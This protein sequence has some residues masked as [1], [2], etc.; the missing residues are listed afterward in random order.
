MEAARK[1][2]KEN[3]TKPQVVQRKEFKG[4]AFI[5][6][7]E[8]IFFKDF[9]VGKTHVQT[10][11]LTNVS[12]S[13]N[14][15]KVLPLD[16]A[17]TDFFEIKYT[18]SGRMS[19]G[20]STTIQITFIP[21]LNQ[22]INSVLPLLAETGPINIP[23]ICTCK[24]AL[25]EVEQP[26]IDFGHVIFGEQATRNLHV[27]NN[28]ALPA[29]IFIKTSRGDL[30]P[31]L[32]ED[33]LNEKRAQ[34]KQKM[35]EHEVYKQRH[36]REQ[37]EKAARDSQAAEGQ[38]P[39]PPEVE[40][41]DDKE[42]KPITQDEIDRAL[43][44]LVFKED[45]FDEFCVQAIFKR[46]NNI[47]S[48]TSKNL[49]FTFKPIKLGR[50]FQECT[51]YLDNQDYTEPIPIII[52]GECVDVPIHV[53]R[54]TYNLNILVYEKTYREK[55]VLYNRSSNTMKLQLY[56]PKEL[57]NY[58]EFNPTLGYIQ[59]NDKFEIWMKF[60]PD[61]TIL[62]V[63]KKYISE[64]NHIDIPIKVVG[65][66]QVIPVRFNIIGRFTVNAVTFNPPSIDFGNVYHTSA[67]RVNMTMENHSLLPQQFYFANLPREIKVETDNGCGIILPGESYKFTI[68]YRPSQTTTYEESEVFC[69]II[70]GNI[71]SREVKISYK[72][73]VMRL[74]LKLTHSLIEFPGLPEKETVEIVTQIENPTQKTYMVELLPP[75]PKLS[76]IMLTPVVMQIPPQKSSLVSIKYKAAFRDFN[77]QTLEKLRKEEE[78]GRRAKEVQGLIQDDEAA[79]KDLVEDDEKNKKRKKRRN[80]KLGKYLFQ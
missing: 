51:L 1:R 79:D 26:I 74:P 43:E 38:Q 52:K 9:D 71:C 44:K 14:S 23:L 64:G 80:K 19:A 24:K 7:P 47:G 70:T 75:N 10:I 42:P 62:S 53:E 29:K 78:A 66:N 28:G 11:L 61:R 8:T 17:I 4:T 72:V 37:Q 58:L 50:I 13:F 73:N 2:H 46:E 33:E 18:P 63:G 12:F 67:S 3:L 49:S 22:D 55:I 59:G 32:T 30:I 27:V 15:F 54:L 31:D 20:L 5:S 35:I 39:P 21:Q 57:K 69:R 65:A 16:D 36:L 6:K 40:G 41:E 25:I 60:K 77:S 76:G 68:V 48:Y 34:E 56:F 45:E